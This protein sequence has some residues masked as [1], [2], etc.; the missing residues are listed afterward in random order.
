M[1]NN[2]RFPTTIAAAFSGFL[3]LIM[4]AITL[5]FDALDLVFSSRCFNYYLN[6]DG[7]QLSQFE[8][9]MCIIG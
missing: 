5:G 9:M 3:I 2:K 7:P 4:F 8:Q 6:T 1:T